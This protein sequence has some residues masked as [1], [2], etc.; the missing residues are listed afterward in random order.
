M[1]VSP[2]PGQYQPEILLR[3]FGAINPDG[4]FVSHTRAA[5]IRLTPSVDH[6]PSDT[7]LLDR[8]SS[9]WDE[10]SMSAWPPTE[11]HQNPKL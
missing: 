9:S 2:G 11:S 8:S 1:L 4:R 6:I 5:R 10:L 7:W 3:C